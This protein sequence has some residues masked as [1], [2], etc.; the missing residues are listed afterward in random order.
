MSLVMPEPN[1][2]CQWVFDGEGVATRKYDGTAVLIKDGEMF[3]R[4]EVKKGK[5]APPD[6]V[7]VDADPNT[8][9][10][11]GWVPAKRDDPADR[12]HWEAFDLTTLIADGT[13]ELVGPKIQSHG[14][15]VLGHTLIRHRDATQYPE[16][17]RDFESLADWLEG[18]DIEGIVFHHD[19]GR[20]A[21]IK[22]RDFGIKRRPCPSTVDTK[23]RTNN[24]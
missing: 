15:G 19:D 7:E 4:R 21:K 23:R 18:K 24:G 5:E 20:M 2:V 14:E 1:P 11:F 17:P 13:C 16:C 10:R 12:Y 6:F 9:K 22:K 8:G 3:K